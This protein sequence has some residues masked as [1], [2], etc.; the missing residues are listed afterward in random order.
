MGDGDDDAGGKKG[1][2][3]LLET[4]NSDQSTSAIEK[5]KMSDEIQQKFEKFLEIYE[6]KSSHLLFF[7]PLTIVKLCDVCGKVHTFCDE[8]E[9][10][11]AEY[12]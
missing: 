10:N 3:M 9:R 4:D 5:H 8:N 1:T 12:G 2:R 7:K 6:K 11:S